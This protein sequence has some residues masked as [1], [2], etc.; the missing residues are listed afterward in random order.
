MGEIKKNAKRR[1]KLFSFSTFHRWWRWIHLQFNFRHFA[2][3]H[4][5]QAW[6]GGVVVKKFKSSNRMLFWVG[7]NW[8][9]DYCCVQIAKLTNDVND[10]RA[11]SC[12]KKS[13]HVAELSNR[14]TYEWVWPKFRN[15]A[16]TWNSLVNSICAFTSTP[17]NSLSN[18]RKGFRKICKLKNQI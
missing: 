7:W 18:P 15:P 14:P 10:S 12:T 8:N 16:R 4:S 1:R 2:G 11:N 5:G 6:G 13:H 17:N 9:S 3:I